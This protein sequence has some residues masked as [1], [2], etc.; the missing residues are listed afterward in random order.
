MAQVDGTWAR[1]YRSEVFALRCID[2][3]AEQSLQLSNLDRTV[4]EA[5]LACHRHIPIQ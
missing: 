4:S 3:R 1:V 5:L 2:L